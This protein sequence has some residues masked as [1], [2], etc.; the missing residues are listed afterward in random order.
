MAIGLHDVDCQATRSLPSPMIGISQ[1]PSLLPTA[2]ATSEESISVPSWSLTAHFPWKRVEPEAHSLA[3]HCSCG[4]AQAG[5]RDAYNEDAFRYLLTIE[6]KRFERSRRP[7]VLVL[8]DLEERSGQT[9]GMDAAL[10]TKVFDG[11]GHALRETDL[12]GWYHEG[13]TIGAVLTHLGD[14]RVAD[15]SRQMAERV[16]RTLR[17]D[18]PDR[19]ARRLQVRLYQPLTR[20]R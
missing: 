10:S 14:A 7:F 18:L 11:L 6:R 8:V 12:I 5:P 17:D 20:V 1:I 3:D 13:R 16:A 4:L 15:V 2:T 9:D 19:V